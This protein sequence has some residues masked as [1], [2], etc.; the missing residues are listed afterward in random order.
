[1]K[2]E[3]RRAEL[4]YLI[5]WR[6]FGCGEYVLGLEPGNCFPEG[7]SAM[8]HKGMLRRLEPG[9]S[10]STFVRVTLTQE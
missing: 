3:Y 9:E 5:Q 2:L 1:M 4:P 7:Q 10:V 6:Q 8:E